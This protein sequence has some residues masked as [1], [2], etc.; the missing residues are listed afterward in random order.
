MREPPQLAVTARDQLLQ[1]AEREM[2]AFE[3]REIEFRKRDRN[4]RAAELNLPLRTE[5]PE[6]SIGAGRRHV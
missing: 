6:G 3:R 5:W 1:A 2:V 4:E